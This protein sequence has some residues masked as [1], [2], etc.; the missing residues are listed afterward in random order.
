MTL[1]SIAGEGLF[2]VDDAE[3][4]EQQAAEQRDE[5]PIEPLGGDQG[6][7]D[8]EDAAGEQDVHVSGPAARRT[9][10][11]GEIIRCAGRLG[12]D[13][14]RLG[15]TYPPGP[16]LAATTSD[17]RPRLTFIVSRSSMTQELYTVGSSVGADRRPT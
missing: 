9:D 6:V 7:G 11:P 1:K 15:R 17:V 8:D 5:R 10:G 14:L 2:L 13:G 3:D 16:S 4:D 12:D